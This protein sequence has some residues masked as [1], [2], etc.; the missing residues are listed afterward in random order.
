MLHSAVFYLILLA[1][2]VAPSGLAHRTHR[3]RHGGH[4]GDRGERCTPTWDSVGNATKICG[5]L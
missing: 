4:T 5:S 1:L 2:S 3:R